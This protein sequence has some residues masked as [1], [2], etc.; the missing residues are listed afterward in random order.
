[1]FKTANVLLF[2]MSEKK[3]H[4]NIGLCVVNKNNTCNVTTVRSVSHSSTLHVR[5][6]STAGTMLNSAGGVHFIA[7]IKIS[8]TL[9][10][11]Y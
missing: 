2:G 3:H 11:R 6:V 9:H 10:G 4:V 1:V 8:R 5:G 7:K